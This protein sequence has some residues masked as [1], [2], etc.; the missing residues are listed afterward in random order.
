MLHRDEDLL[1]TSLA[2][3]TLS[4]VEP[5]G[6]GVSHS[7]SESSLL[8]GAFNGREEAR[9]ETGK[10]CGGVE[11][12]LARKSERRLCDRVV[13][14]VEDKLDSVADIS[15]EIVLVVEEAGILVGH[16]DNDLLRGCCTGQSQSG[17]SKSLSEVH[18]ELFCSSWIQYKRTER[19][20]NVINQKTAVKRLEKRKTLELA[21]K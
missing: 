18:L 15:A 9:V 7:V 4:T 5:M 6:T 20:E 12:R 11:Q 19:R 13:E 3:S 16:L 17:G 10:A 21:K 2:V 8:C 1:L 14:R